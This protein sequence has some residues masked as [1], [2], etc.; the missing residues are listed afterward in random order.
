MFAEDA[1]K[2]FDTAF[3]RSY[4]HLQMSIIPVL[5]AELKNG[6]AAKVNFFLRQAK[7]REI[8]YIA[9]TSCL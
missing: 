2:L 6:E 4:V 1:I 3:I 5:H 9:F 8:S 7:R